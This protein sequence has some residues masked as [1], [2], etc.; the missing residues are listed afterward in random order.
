MNK[1]FHNVSFTRHSTSHSS[2]RIKYST[3]LKQHQQPQNNE[4]SASPSS[5]CLYCITKAVHPRLGRGETYICGYKPYRC[6]ICNYST[7]TKGN[8]AIH[9]QSDKHLNNLQEHE[10]TVSQT[11][12]SSVDIRSN[13]TGSPDYNRYQQEQQQHNLNQNRHHLNLTSK[14]SYSLSD[15][16]FLASHS[17]SEIKGM[18]TLQQNIKLSHKNIDSVQ[19]R[20]E[21]HE[22]LDNT[23]TNKTIRNLY[24]L[25]LSNNEDMIQQFNYPSPSISSFLPNSFPMHHDVTL[26]TLMPSTSSNDSL[27][28]NLTE[29]SNH[30][31]ACQVCC[32][33]TTDNLDMLIEHAERKPYT[34]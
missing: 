16:K 23:E 8:L 11:I 4:G 10:Q 14:K 19:N 28:S 25:G 29:T 13:H 32:T 3:M 31:L 7:T 24:E 18:K 5:S 33:F 17:L 9:Q 30:P 12:F 27:T 15:L 2:D 1:A 26:N 21:E 22:T 6:E 20:N 34:V